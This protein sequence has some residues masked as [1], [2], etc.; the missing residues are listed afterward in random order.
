[1]GHRMVPTPP[2]GQDAQTLILL[3][4]VTMSLLEWALKV[5]GTG[6]L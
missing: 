2:E 1:M 3:M 6:C 4:Q 5:G